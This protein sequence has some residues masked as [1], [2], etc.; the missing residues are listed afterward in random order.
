VRTPSQLATIIFARITHSAGACRDPASLR[1]FRSS[2]ASAGARA[3]SNFGMAITSGG[4]AHPR[5]I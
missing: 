4:T 3:C 5:M 1:I 2:S